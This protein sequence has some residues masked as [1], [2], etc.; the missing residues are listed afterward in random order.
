VVG[1]GS[2]WETEIVSG[3]HP[4][5]GHAHR[6]S[7]DHVFLPFALGADWKIF[8]LGAH[9]EIGSY[10]W[11]DHHLDGGRVEEVVIGLDDDDDGSLLLR[12]IRGAHRL[13][14]CSRGALDAH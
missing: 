4:T 10:D 5:F 12:R 6:Y 8:G 7:R 3:G 11:P 14:C 1:L 9:R 13:P 2:A